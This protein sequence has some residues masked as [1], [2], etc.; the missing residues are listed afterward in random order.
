MKWYV[1]IALRM[2]SAHC[3]LR[4]EPER[5]L[6]PMKGSGWLGWSYYRCAQGIYGPINPWYQAKLWDA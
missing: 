3:P 1:K 5:W 6:H 4:E 2:R